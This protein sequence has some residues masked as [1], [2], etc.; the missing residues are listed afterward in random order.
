MAAH[1]QTLTSSSNQL[2]G[3]RSVA[4]DRAEVSPLELFLPVLSDT[5]SK[6]DAI[7]GSLVLILFHIYA[8][9][10][11]LRDGKIFFHCIKAG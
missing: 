6:L 8:L 2:M 1:V 10:W 7:P 5:S 4:S 9:R 11:I 3:Y